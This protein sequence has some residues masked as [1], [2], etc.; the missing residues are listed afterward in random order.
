M[1]RILIIGS[2]G[3]GKTTFAKKLSA[4]TGL[5]LVHIDKLYWRGCWEVAP[6]EEFERA[7]LQ[8]ARHPRWIIEGNNIRTLHQ[9]LPFADTVF[10]FEF[11]PM[12]CLWNI[13]KREIRYFRKARPDMPE[14]CIS[15]LSLRFLRDIW[16][17][18]RKNH[19][20]IESALSDFPHVH[21]I[22][23]TNYTQMRK[24][25]SEINAKVEYS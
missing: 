3:A 25:L 11:P 21:V 17:F 10:W 4:A 22:R 2:N 1:E 15:K 16:N 18:N 13:L 5:P 20:R 23:F 8:E 19:M 6:P 14:G 7:V 9:R 24:Y 12:L